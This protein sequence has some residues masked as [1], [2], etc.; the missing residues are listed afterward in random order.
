M[1]EV[2][3]QSTALQLPTRVRLPFGLFRAR[4]RLVP[5]ISQ[6]EAEYKRQD[7]SQSRTGSH[8]SPIRYGKTLQ[9]PTAAQAGP[10]TP[11][12]REP[13]RRNVAE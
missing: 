10:E 7:G 5:C 13:T 3:L 9:A 11:Q 4:H 8:C 6:E 12:G 2:S 1:D